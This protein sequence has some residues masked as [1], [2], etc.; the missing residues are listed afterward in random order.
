MASTRW[1]NKES[2]GAGMIVLLGS[3]IAYAGYGYGVGRLE[4]MDSGFVPLA[5]GVAMTVVG[6]LLGITTI[7]GSS[8]EKDSQ[9]ME[10]VHLSGWPDLRGGI[11]IVAGVIA[12]VIL[13]EYG[14]LVPA[15]FASVFI[16][17]LGDRKNSLRDALLLSC[18]MV[19]LAL[20]IFSWALKVQMPA[21][22]WL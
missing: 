6:L 15:T 4:H 22:T 18:A 5:I 1:L 13:G 2:F 21:F 11:C 7:F 14:G 3:A 8:S 16:S 19:G 9:D 20:V 12:F 10:H 17:A